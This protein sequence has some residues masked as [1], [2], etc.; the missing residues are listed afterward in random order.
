ML[1]KIIYYSFKVF[2]VLQKICRI[3]I[4]VSFL[5]FVVSILNIF[6]LDKEFASK[7]G[8]V[9]ILILMASVVIGFVLEASISIYESSN[10]LMESID[11][12]KKA[13]RI[14]ERY[15]RNRNRYS[16]RRHNRIVKRRR[17]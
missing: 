7:I 10:I 11:L 12:S 1:G 13:N 3:L 14:I 9:A 6:E 4:F 2:R 17:K 8:V 15:K 5:V 16:K